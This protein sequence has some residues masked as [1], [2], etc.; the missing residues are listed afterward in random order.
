MKTTNITAR[1]NSKT[2]SMFY[3]YA[4][5]QHKSAESALSEAVDMYAEY[6]GKLDL[7]SEPF[8]HTKIHVPWDVYGKLNGS[9]LEKNQ[10][11][12]EA[13]NQAM[14]LFVRKYDIEM[15]NNVSNG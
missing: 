15:S 11:P 12:N 13:W 3:A 4:T 5:I 2:A 6:T 9:R 8:K 10:S 7:I 1:V 14:V